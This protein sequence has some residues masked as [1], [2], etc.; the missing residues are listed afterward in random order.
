MRE[1]TSENSRD[2]KIRTNVSN[3]EI[4]SLEFLLPIG[5]AVYKGFVIRSDVLQQFL[6]MVVLD[7]TIIESGNRHAVNVEGNS[8]DGCWLVLLKDMD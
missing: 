3:D 1:M 8:V 6:V 5:I 4:L 7:A 2:C